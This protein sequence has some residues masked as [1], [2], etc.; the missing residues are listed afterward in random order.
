M[1]NTQVFTIVLFLM[2]TF[3]AGLTYADSITLDC[4]TDHNIQKRGTK[5][6]LNVEF[7][8]DNRKR[9]SFESSS[10]P[11]ELC[12]K[13]QSQYGVNFSDYYIGSSG[14]Y[15]V[16]RYINVIAT[17]DDAFYLDSAVANVGIGNKQT[18]SKF[19]NDNGRGW[20]L[21]TDPQDGNGKLKSYV[22][23]CHQCLEFDVQ[24]NKVNKSCKKDWHDG[25]TI[26]AFTTGSLRTHAPEARFVRN[27]SEWEMQ[28]LPA[29]TKATWIA[30]RSTPLVVTMHRYDPYM[31][32]IINLERKSVYEKRDIDD[33]TQQVF[34][35]LHWQ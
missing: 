20:C 25:L 23:G 26:K 28:T 24:T 34:K 1:S 14:E 35:L 11:N 6:T 5:G 30:G 32:Y 21:S 10:V 3:S 19:G 9:I 4:Y 29:G 33:K 31:Q 17:S 27:G 22:D 7:L 16:T 12:T 2:S 18:S 15:L 13:E 8:D